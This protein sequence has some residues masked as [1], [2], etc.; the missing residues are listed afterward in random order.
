[1][2]VRGQEG[3]GRRAEA[4]PPVA[5]CGARS[6]GPA[7]ERQPYSGREGVGGQIGA[8]QAGAASGCRDA[9]GPAELHGPLRGIP[10]QGGHPGVAGARGLLE[11]FYHWITC[12]ETHVGA[13]IR[14]QPLE[15]LCLTLALAHEHLIRFDK[16]CYQRC[17]AAG[18]HVGQTVLGAFDAAGWRQQNRGFLA[19]ETDQAYLVALLIGVEWTLLCFPGACRLGLCRVRRPPGLGLLS[20]CPQPL[21][22]NS[23]ASVYRALRERGVCRY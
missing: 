8:A 2:A 15:G 18:T 11:G 23:T 5:E 9:L 7:P 20:S 6:R 16:A 10:H 14:K 12:A 22:F 17:A 21:T 13:A 4:Q 19:M 1:M 3:E